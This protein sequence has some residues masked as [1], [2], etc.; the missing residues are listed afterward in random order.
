MKEYIYVCTA[1]KQYPCLLNYRMDGQ[2]EQ[3][4]DV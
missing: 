2:Y 1:K 3:K 4:R